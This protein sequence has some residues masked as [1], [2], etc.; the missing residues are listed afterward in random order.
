MKQTQ[1]MTFHREEQVYTNSAVKDKIWHIWESTAECQSGKTGDEVS[2]RAKILKTICTNS[3]IV[4]FSVSNW[5]ISD[6]FNRNVY[7]HVHMHICVCVNFSTYTIYVTRFLCWKDCFCNMGGRFKGGDWM[8]QLH[9]QFLS[10]W[11]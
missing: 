8:G 9:T 4:A 10:Q 6:K 5:W 11:L 1:E 2:L 7:R 3:R